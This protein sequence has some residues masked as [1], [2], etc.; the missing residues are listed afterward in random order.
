MRQIENDLKQKIEFKTMKEDELEKQKE[1]NKSMKTE[2]TNKIKE[3]REEHLKELFKEMVKLRETKKQNDDIC[4]HIK[5]EEQSTNKNKYEF[6]KC[7]KNLIAEKKRALKV[8]E[9]KFQFITKIL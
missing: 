7:Q 2:I 1:Y 4:R 6:I 3:K 9:I 5:I 8:S